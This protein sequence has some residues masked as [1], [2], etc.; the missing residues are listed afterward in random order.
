MGAPFYDNLLNF[1][2]T[3]DLELSTDAAMDLVDYSL[4][5]NGSK[6]DGARIYSLT[7]AKGS[8]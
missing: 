2:S 6:G 1:T 7:D 5:V 3:P 8:A 4:I